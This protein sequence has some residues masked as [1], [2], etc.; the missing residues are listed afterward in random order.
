MGSGEAK[1]FDVML[2]QSDGAQEDEAIAST[3]LDDL[4]NCLPEPLKDEVMVMVSTDFDEPIEDIFDSR[5]TPRDN[6]GS[7][8]SNQPVQFLSFTQLGKLLG[9]REQDLLLSVSGASQMFEEMLARINGALSIVIGYVHSRA[10]RFSLALPL[11]HLSL[12]FRALGYV[13]FLFGLVDLNENSVNETINSLTNLQDARIQVAYEKL[14][15][16]TDIERCIHMDLFLLKEVGEV[17]DVQNIKQ[18]REYEKPL[19]EAVE[20]IDDKWNNQRE[21]F[22]QRTGL[23]H[24]KPAEEQLQLQLIENEVENNDGDE[25]YRLLYEHD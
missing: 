2:Y 11:L 18:I 1:I 5:A 14:F 8:N 24:R 20:K 25:F 22:Y 9:K 23:S 4:S 3:D 12:P 13:E 10:I 16:D 7:V 17:V 6:V 15:P 21:V 19:S